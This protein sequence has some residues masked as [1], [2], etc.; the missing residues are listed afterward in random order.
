MLMTCLALVPVNKDMVQATID[1]LTRMLG[2]SGAYA[3][4]DDPVPSRLGDQRSELVARMCTCMYVWVRT[5]HL[6]E[7]S[8]LRAR[9]TRVCVCVHSDADARARLSWA[10][11]TPAKQVVARLNR[12]TRS[13][14]LQVATQTDARHCQADFTGCPS[15][16]LPPK[17]LRRRRKTSISI[18]LRKGTR[19]RRHG[20]MLRHT[21]VP[22][23]RLLQIARMHTT[24]G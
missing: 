17:T 10:Y 11:H 14:A 2:P 22:R 4:Y 20:H 5:L 12:I 16:Y 18:I 3:N 23:D 1:T 8:L 19:A 21:S 15:K 6:G 9:G 24:H 7:G 13:H